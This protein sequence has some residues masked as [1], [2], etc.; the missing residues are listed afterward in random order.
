MT[1]RKVTSLAPFLN[2]KPL[3][4]N[5]AS[6]L[7]GLAMVDDLDG[8]LIVF[9]QNSRLGNRESEFTE[10][11][12]EVPA[13]FTALDSSKEFGFGGT[14]GNNG[15]GFNTKGNGGAGHD[16]SITGGRTLGAEIVGMG[17]INDSKGFHKIGNLGV[18]QKI[19]GVEVSRDRC[20]REMR[21]GGMVNGAPIDEAPVNS[22]TKVFCDPF[23]GDEMD[24]GGCS[25]EL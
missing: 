4:I 8:R 25:R 11:G 10:D 1:N 15:L 24:P 23:K 7:S 13:Y 19:I 17:G 21:E 6:K 22:A 12:T 14:G 16:K 5:M 20:Q 3:D 2:S 9:K 18:D